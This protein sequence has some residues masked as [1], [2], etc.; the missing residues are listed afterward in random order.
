MRFKFGLWLVA[1]AV[2]VVFAFQTGASAQANRNLAPGTTFVSGPSMM[3]SLPAGNWQIRPE[4]T[5]RTVV[6]SDLPQA[7]A[8]QLAQAP[9]GFRRPLD[10][11]TDAQHRAAKLEAGQR[12]GLSSTG[13]RP[14]AGT[15]VPALSF[16]YNGLSQAFACPNCTPPDEA[17]AVAYSFIVQAVNVA[18]NVSAK[19]DGLPRGLYPK[20]L[21]S[22]FGVPANTFLTDPR[23]VF[24]WNNNHFILIVLEEDFG[25]SQ[26]LLDIGVS[27][28]SD[29]TGAWSTFR[30]PIGGPTAFDCADYPTLGQDHG[31][32]VGESL[33]GVYVGINWFTNAGGF[34]NGGYDNNSLFLISKTALYSGSVSFIQGTGFFEPSPGT[35]KILDT[36]QPANVS[37]RGGHPRAAFFTATENI[38]FGN[39]QCRLGGTPAQCHGVTVWA[40]SNPFGW[41][42]AAVV[43]TASAIYNP[44]T[45]FYNFPANASQPGFPQS[46][47]TIDTRI[48]GGTNYS[49]GGIFA[50]WETLDNAFAPEDTPIW[51]EL[52]PILND[53]GGGCSGTFL[54]ACPTLVSL[55]IRQ[56]DFFNGVAGWANQG[57]A[58]FAY[59]QPDVENNVGMVFSYADNAT[60]PLVVYTGRRVTQTLSTMQGIGN[61]AQAGATAYLEFRWGDYAAGAL[62]IASQ[63]FPS[64]WLA[65][66]KVNPDS[67][68]GTQII[69]FAYI[70]A[71]RP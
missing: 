27:A 9:G 64:F 60:F 68:W 55:E 7:T 19:K 24:D 8:A 1:V 50:A 48:S 26:S 15:F 49:A 46:I 17:V 39:G 51:V 11:L 6:M 53:N 32:W 70:N 63:G 23:L 69:N 14:G 45:T 38:N 37:D 33:G 42:V 66:Q 57:T 16:N 4:V 31:V 59:L 18:I 2:A 62:D 34:C 10:G 56:D 43:P 61:V 41:R 40:V 13:P 71:N 35:G 25:T 5:G 54:N 20:L 44:N 22:F 30:V 21:T 58:F 52:R 65:T 29:P 36:L 47:E 3:G 12:G 28:T 67:T